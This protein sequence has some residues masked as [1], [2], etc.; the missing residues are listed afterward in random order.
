[1][2]VIVNPRDLLLQGT[3]TRLGTISLPPNVVIPGVRPDGTAPPGPINFAAVGSFTHVIFTH[4]PALFAEGHGYAR[5][6][7]YAKI[8]T[9]DVL[10]TFANATRLTSFT[11]TVFAHPMNAGISMRVW[12]TWES[13]DG[14]ESQPAGGMNGIFVKTDQDI[15]VFLKALEGQLSQSQLNQ[16][17]GSRID[18]IGDVADGTVNSRI[19]RTEQVFQ[20]ALAAEAIERSKIIATIGSGGNIMGN[21]EFAVNLGG[22]AKGSG[23]TSNVTFGRNLAPEWTVEPGTAYIQEVGD[24]GTFPYM[25]VQTTPFVIEPGKRY[26]Y[27]IY[28]AAHRARVSIFIYWYDNNNAVIGN[29]T[30]AFNDEE[31][32]GGSLLS[33]YKRLGSFGIAPPNAVTGRAMLRKERTKIGFNHTSSYAFFTRAYFGLATSDQTLFTPYS[34]G[35]GGTLAAAVQTEALARATETGEL[36]AQYTV[37]VDVN[38]YVAGF[39]LASTLR[40]GVPTSEFIIRADTFAIAAVDTDPNASDGSPFFYRSVGSTI[41]GTFVPAGAYMKSAFILDASI[42]NAKIQNAAID[43]A[44]I[45][46]VNVGKLT[47]GSLRFDTYISSSNF[48]DNAQGIAIWGSGDVQLNNLRARGEIN[49]GNFTGYAW[50]LNGGGGSHLSVNGLLVGNPAQNRYFQLTNGGDLYAPQFSI[51]GGNATFSGNL[52]AVNGTFSGVLTAQAINAV[53]TMNI[54][55]GAVTVPFFAGLNSSAYGGL[56]SYT[57]TQFIP[58]N[59]IIV[60]FCTFSINHPGFHGANC[61]IQVRSDDFSITTVGTIGFSFEN[62]GAGT[63]SGHFIA[64]RD[65]YYSISATVNGDAGGTCTNCVITALGGKR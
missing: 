17:L 45:A 9:N 10:P 1:M 51:V 20:T 53:D 16:S 14:V 23:F 55:G 3:P 32:F 56:N 44:K 8:Q 24:N 50:P 25:E 48:I 28:T 22:W 63:A 49:T 13:R 12:A 6:N 5:T 41:N 34:S 61:A 33:G 40:N 15:Q 47:A 27:S 62:Y 46:N 52:S 2:S 38:G 7:I 60:V 37:K 65:A 4:D 58:A 59:S 64:P 11:G 39:G 43:D 26:E 19:A 35:G 57:A 18:L 54:R 42:T 31:Q 21:P 29:S 36:Y 30:L